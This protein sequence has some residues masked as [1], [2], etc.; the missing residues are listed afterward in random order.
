MIAVGA[1]E[2]AVL[3]GVLAGVLVQ[4]GVTV[5]LRA[6]AVA[7]ARQNP[8]RSWQLAASLPYVGLALWAIGVLVTAGLLVGSFSAVAAVDPA[9]KVPL[10]VEAIRGAMVAIAVFFP[11]SFVV[12]VAS[13]ALS[14][15]GTL[16][17]PG[18]AELA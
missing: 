7:V 17:P 15:I 14:L 8:A 11:A 13:A 3:S 16:R 2:F 18:P 12:Y 9:D 6:W 10:L 5:A 1:P 4:V